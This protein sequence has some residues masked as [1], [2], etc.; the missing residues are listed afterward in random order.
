M[1]KKYTK[2]DQK[3]LLFGFFSCGDFNNENIYVTI[4]SKEVFEFIKNL[5]IKHNFEFANDKKNQFL[6]K[7]S[8]FNFKEIKKDN[9]FFAGCFLN[10]GSISSIDSVSYHLEIKFFNEQFANLMINI[11]E[12]FDIFFKTI[13]RKSSFVLYLKKIENICDFLKAIEVYQA[14]LDFEEAKIE[15]DFNNNINRITN[16]DFYNQKRIAEVNNRFLNNYKLIIEKQMT[17]LFSQAELTFFEL[18]KENLDLSL[19]ELANLMLSKKIYR[20]KSSLNRYLLKLENIVKK[21]TS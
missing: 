17:E 5:L 9:N 3:A 20:S 1:N 10:G 14:Y 7:Q 8:I 19:I 11:F 16:F 12:K 4:N 6:V 21:L 18:K 2:E 13:Q 15:R